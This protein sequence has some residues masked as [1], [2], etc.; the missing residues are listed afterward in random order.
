MLK[1]MTGFGKATG[2]SSGISVTI[3]IRS[4]NSSKGLDLAIK[5]PAKYREQESIIRQHCGTLLI[6]GKID[7]FISVIS[8]KET[9]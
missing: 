6:R 3:E 5:L 1:S 9:A 7:I 8:E 4:L 2:S